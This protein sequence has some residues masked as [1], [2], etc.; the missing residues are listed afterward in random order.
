MVI[1][2]GDTLHKA[3]GDRLVPVATTAWRI[4]GKG[5]GTAILDDLG[6]RADAR[7]LLGDP[8]GIGVVDDPDLRCVIAVA[9]EARIREFN[10]CF[11]DDADRIRNALDALDAD[12]RADAFDELRALH[13]DGFLF[14]A[15]RAKGRVQALGKIAS[16]SAVDPDVAALRADGFGLAPVMSQLGTFVQ[17]QFG[18]ADGLAMQ[19]AAALLKMGTLIGG[20]GAG[21]GPRPVIRDLLLGFIKSHGGD[22]VEGR[23]DAIAVDG[24]RIASLT[25]EQNKHEVIPRVVVDATAA[26]DLTDRLPS[27]RARE[28]ILAQQGRVTVHGGAIS[29]RWL[30]PISAL[31]K[32]L[33]PVALVLG[34]D[35]IPPVLIGLY[36][37][38]PLSDIGK[39]SHLS[40]DTIAV[41]GTAI[42]KDSSLVDA[43]LRR[44]LPFAHGKA[45][46]TDVVDAGAV[47]G[48]YDVKDSEH[49]LEGRRPRTALKNLFRAGRDLAPAW[50]M[51]G[52]LAAARSVAALIESAFPK[53]SRG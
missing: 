44:V 25:T 53:Q 22:V 32:G 41:V 34:A 10:R 52:E 30:L 4:P 26:R 20:V 42:V 17:S 33:P 45:R 31:P 49:P 11:G 23:V 21:L 50:G 29:V 19:Q 24:S 3:L 28:K 36:Q 6:L 48:H 9:P 35:G 14:E 43:A 39:D 13:E 47:C 15:R 8:V 16:T 18:G 27:S 38:A 7:R 46:A 12:S 1:D 51:D 2:D 40:D 37:G 5:P